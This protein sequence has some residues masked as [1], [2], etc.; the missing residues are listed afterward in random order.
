MA[1]ETPRY[2]F[3][4]VDGQTFYLEKNRR[5]ELAGI[6]LLGKYVL[7][8]VADPGFGHFAHDCEV[9]AVEV[10]HSELYKK[11]SLEARGVDVNDTCRFTKTFNHQGFITINLRST[12]RTT[13]SV[14]DLEAGY[15]LN[16]VIHDDYD[17]DLKTYIMSGKLEEA[18]VR[19]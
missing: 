4:D 14:I 17:H 2:R 3:Y 10:V 12:N 11:V 16:E 8:H 6:K 18:K 15:L 13:E 1:R 9:K 19:P 7:R 5:I